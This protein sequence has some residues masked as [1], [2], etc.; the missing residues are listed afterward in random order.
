M[1]ASHIASYDSLQSLVRIFSW[2]GSYFSLV[3][4]ASLSGSSS[5]GI[6]C[7]MNARDFLVYNGS[8]TSMYRWNGGSGVSQL[9]SIGTLKL[10]N[11]YFPSFAA[12]NGTDFA[13]IDYT[14]SVLELY[15]L[16]FSLSSPLLR[17]A[18]QN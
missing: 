5:W 9:T 2:S 8:D 12:A 18:F 15:R 4:S 1:D 14:G 13:M 17:G 16:S 7:A 6:V 3:A 10:G 11:T